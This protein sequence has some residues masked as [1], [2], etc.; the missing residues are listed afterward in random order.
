MFLI[1]LYMQNEAYAELIFLG[2]FAWEHISMSKA[3]AYRLVAGCPVAIP[4]GLDM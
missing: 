4:T 2:I 3:S 1:R